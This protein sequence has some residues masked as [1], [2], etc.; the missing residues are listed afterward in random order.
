MFMK[1]RKEIR[2][3][4]GR[5][6]QNMMQIPPDD[7]VRAIIDVKD[8]KDEDLLTSIILFFVLKKELLKK[9]NWKISAVQDKPG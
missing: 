9:Q 4:K 3:S 1:F 2:H 6:I 8:L 7:K 5:A